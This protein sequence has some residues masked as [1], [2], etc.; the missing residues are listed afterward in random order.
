MNPLPTSHRRLALALY[1]VST[2]LAFPQEWPGIGAFD[3]GLVFAGLGPA[4]LVVGLSGLPARQAA[5]EAFVASLVGH[6]LLFHWFIVVTVTYGGMPLV[7]GLLAPLLP[8]YW[9]AQFSALFA[10]LW[11]RLTQL[12]RGLPHPKR[13]VGAGLLQAPPR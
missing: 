5:R 9:V 10:A 2:V 1:A 12:A 6:A 7:L 13:D 8:G 11:A 3:L 4:A